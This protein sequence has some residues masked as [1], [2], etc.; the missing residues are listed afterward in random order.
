MIDRRFFR[1]AGPTRLSDIA[2]LT[3]ASLSSRS[4]D[5]PDGSRTFADVAPLD[6]A[7]PQDISFFDNIKY[8]DAFTQSRAGACFTRARFTSRA[9]EGMALL[10]TE[11]PYTGFALTAQQFYPEPAFEP[12]IAP[13]A[14][15]AASA[16]IGRNSRIDAGAVI[17][18]HVTIGE[19]C[20]IG[21]NTVIYDHVQIGDD[22]RIG[23]CCTISHALL[24]SRI[25]LHRGIHI[26]QDGFGFAPGRTGILKVPQLGRVLIGDNVEIG[27]GTTIDRGSGPDTVIGQGSKIDNLVQIGHNV[28]IGKYVII[29]GQCGIAGSTRIDDGVMLGGQVGIGGHVHIGAGAKLAAQSGVMRDIPAGETYSGSP[30]MPIRE[31]RRQAA[32]MMKL[33]KKGEASEE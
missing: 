30:A 33:G 24:G 7:G 11:E 16:K 5:A 12:N 20:H 2:S 9:P 25:T 14:V 23:A 6:Q 19:R 1:H 8:I 28:Q 22:C 4:G 21:A 27:S 10:V 3:A 15:I 31:W 32:T 13:Q 17:G 18:E 26:G 29:A